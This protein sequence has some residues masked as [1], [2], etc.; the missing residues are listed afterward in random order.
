MIRETLILVSLGFIAAAVWNHVW[1]QPNDEFRF[2]VMDC[3]TET[4][5]HDQAGYNIC[6]DRVRKSKKA[7]D[8]APR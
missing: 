5:R 1:I 3:M 4:D 6:V 2:A 8:N 7:L